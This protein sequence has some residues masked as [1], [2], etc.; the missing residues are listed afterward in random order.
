MHEIVDVDDYHDVANFSPDQI[1]V[2]RLISSCN[3]YICLGRIPSDRSSESRHMSHR[4]KSSRSLI[5][6]ASEDDPVVHD[7][8]IIGM[9]APAIGRRIHGL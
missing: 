3:D 7:K 4:P 9:T 2:S 6:G 5:R 8:H 1:D